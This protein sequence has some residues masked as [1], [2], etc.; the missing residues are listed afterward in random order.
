M[1][2]ILTKIKMAVSN[3]LRQVE[4]IKQQLAA[5]GQEVGEQ[6]L[7]KHVVTPQL[8]SAYRQAQ[9][10]VLTAHGIEEGDLEEAVNKYIAGG[11]KELTSIADTMRNIYRSLGGDLGDDDEQEAASAGTV[12]VVVVVVVVVGSGSR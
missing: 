5:S 9:D 4:G 1:R 10:A 6:E 7:L 3:F 8:D 2:E 11:D 12:V